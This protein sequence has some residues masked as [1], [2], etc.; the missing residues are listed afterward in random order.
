MKV[1]VDIRVDDCAGYFAQYCY[2]T[3]WTILEL[4]M[5]VV[6]DI[7]VD[8]RTGYDTQHCYRLGYRGTEHESG[9]SSTG[10]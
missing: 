6:V 3:G 5:K 9:Y 1:V 2:V 4:I 7:R 10:R 8:D